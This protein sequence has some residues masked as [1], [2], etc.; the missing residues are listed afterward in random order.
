MQRRRFLVFALALPLVATAP[1]LARAASQT[2]RT[3]G[4]VRY[5]A[6]D[7]RRVRIRH[8]DIPGFMKAMTMPF[9]ATPALL[10][11][12]A[13]GDHVSFTFEA[14]DDGSCVIVSLARVAVRGSGSASRK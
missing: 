4:I 14:R 12:V 5:I 10:A 9:D 11:G 6:Q 7:R 3:R 1:R 2:Y 13:E 8:D